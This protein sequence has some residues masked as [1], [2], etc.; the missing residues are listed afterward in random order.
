MKSKNVIRVART[1]DAV[2]VGV[3]GLGNMNN[4]IT[5]RAF[6]DRMVSTGYRRFVVDLADC[7][8]MDSTFLG[9]LFSLTQTPPGTDRAEVIVVNPS[10]TTLKL[11]EEV[12]LNAVLKVKREATSVPSLSFEVLEES[13]DPDRRLQTIREAHENLLRLDRKNEEQFGPFLKALSKELQ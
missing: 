5:F 10:P 11:L 7:R 4:S 13:T 3:V 12:G 2:F 6:A 1:K 9:I 8:G